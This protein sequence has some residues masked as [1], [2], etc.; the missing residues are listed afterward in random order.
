MRRVTWGDWVQ[1]GDCNDIACRANSWYLN[2]TGQDTKEMRCFAIEF[3]AMWMV[4]EKCLDLVVR[5]YWKLHCGGR[6]QKPWRS[7]EHTVY[8]IWISLKKICYGS[9]EVEEVSTSCC[10]RSTLLE[11]RL[12]GETKFLKIWINEVPD[13]NSLSNTWK[14]WRNGNGPGTEELGSWGLA[15][16]RPLNIVLAQRRCSC[17]QSPARGISTT[18]H[19]CCVIYIGFRSTNG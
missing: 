3:C 4:S 10:C 14:N 16:C 15:G 8:D 13:N 12:D 17:N 5:I 11:C 6:Y 7:L 18:S 1:I 9:K 19:L 2:Y